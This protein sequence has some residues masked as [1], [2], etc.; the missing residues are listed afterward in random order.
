MRIPMTPAAVKWWG[1]A[2]VALVAQ[3]SYEPT[4]SLGQLLNA[5]VIIFCAGGVWAGLNKDLKTVKTELIEL[6]EL[7][8][9]YRVLSSSIKDIKDWINRHEEITANR[10]ELLYK[11][12]RRVGELA[13]TLASNIHR[14]N[15]IERRRGDRRVDS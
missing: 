13:A 5:A 10:M 3:V 11:T 14:I 15:Q 12:D 7:T 4:V 2:A 1:A 8:A 9:D 6:K